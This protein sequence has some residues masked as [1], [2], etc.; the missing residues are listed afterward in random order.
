[1]WMWVAYEIKRSWVWA[2][3]ILI[4]AGVCLSR[5]Y[6]AVHDIDD[7]LTGLSLG[8]VGMLIF[9]WMQGPQ[10]AFIRNL[11]VVPHLIIIVAAGVA[12]YL[13]WPNGEDPT[14]TVGLFAL[15]FGWFV[16]ADM[17]R[18]L[19]PAAPQNPGWIRGIIMA[20]TGVAVLLALQIGLGKTVA[21]LG[22]AGIVGSYTVSAVLGFYMTGLAPMAFRAARLSK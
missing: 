13:V 22:F 3:A 15:L 9:I 10:F 14:R 12:L 2:A 1:M 19:A 20:V 5:L 4:V 6:L 17:D 21:A 18:R 16:G 11:T 8:L 7:I